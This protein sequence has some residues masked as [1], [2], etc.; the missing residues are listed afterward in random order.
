MKQEFQDS[1]D[2]YIF[3]MMSDDDK[4]LFEEEVKQDKSKREQLEFTENLKAAIVSREEKLARLTIMQRM[5]DR[6]RHQLAAS[7]RAT[8]TDDRCYSPAPQPQVVQE[9][10][11]RRIWWWVSGIAAVL[12]A[13]FFVI[14][15]SVHDSPLRQLDYS[16][17][18]KGRPDELKRGDDELFNS[19]APAITDSIVNDTIPQDSTIIVLDDDSID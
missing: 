8:G 3:D 4:V 11:S 1:I 9:K 16:P 6:E 12:V 14:K 15:P 7:E 13:G 5:Y 2:D 18:F 19:K 17:T 10:P